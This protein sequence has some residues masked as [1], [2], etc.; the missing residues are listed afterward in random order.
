MTPPAQPTTPPGDAFASAASANDR[1]A[2]AS[3]PQ[4]A[5][6]EILRE[7]GRGGMGVVYEA[8][9]L[10]LNRKVALKV[11]S[12]RLG[13]TAQAVQRFRREAEAAARLHHTNIVPIYATGEHDGQHY[14]AME[15]IEG[16]SLDQV[17]AKLR[18]ARGD[19]PPREEAPALTTAYIPATHTPGR[20]SGL[21]DSSSVGSGGAYFDTAARMIADVADALDYAHRQGVIHRDV[22]PSNLLLGPDGRLSLNDFGLARVLERPGLT[23]TGEFV[24]TPAYMSPEQITA[25]RTPLDHRTDIYSLG[26]TLYELLTLHPPFAG[27]RRDQVLAQI[28]HKEPKA[29]RQVNPKVPVD[30][31]TICLKALEKDPDRRYQTAGAMAED[32]RRYVNRFVITARRAGPVQRMVKWVRRRPAVAASLGLALLAVVAALAFACIAYHEYA[33][34]RAQLLD[35]KIHQAYEVASIGDLKRTDDAIKEVEELGGSP[36]QVRLLRGMA[37][38]FRQDVESAISDL[39][40]AAKLLPDSVAAHALLASAYA[41]KGALEKCEGVIRD[42]AQLSPSSAEDYLFRGW[43]RENNEAGHGF[44]DLDEGIWLHDSPLGRALRALARAN[45]AMDTGRPEDAEAALDDA[46]AAHGMLPENP[47]VLLA[48]V[49]TRVVAAGIYHDAELPQERT[50]VLQDAKRDVQ[51]LE[52][53]IELPNSAYAMWLYYEEVGDGD[54]AVDVTRRC[55]NKTGGMQAA[56]NCAESLYLQDK[57][58]EALDLLDHRRQPDLQGDVLRL[59]LLAEERGPDQALAEYKR[60]DDVYSLAS[61]ASRIKSE[62]LFFLGRKDLA[63]ESLRNLRPGLAFGQENPSFWE[64]GTQFDRGELAEDAVLARAGASRVNQWTVHYQLALRRLAD[65]DRDGAKDHFQKAVDTH[66]V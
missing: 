40:Q 60:F 3:F 45:R 36:G 61:W 30:L 46:N 4:T 32:L 62:V 51:A 63:L 58:K 33:T 25:G 49:Y 64:A 47:L 48:N 38:Y 9:Q 18:Q 26:A 44:A 56:Y 59:F 43:A 55:F 57:R 16:P 1:P 31:E 42:M 41:D 52:R 17:I 65:G 11:L 29:P 2:A 54:S 27:E 5:D 39:E 14:Y 6:Y 23:V 8:R 37:A 34:A 15:L 10:S 50:A 20:A 12:G 28:L 7:L 35:E 24:G 66:V 22:K 13:L 19:S 21:T 53:V